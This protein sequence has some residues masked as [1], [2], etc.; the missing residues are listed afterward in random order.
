MDQVEVDAG[1]DPDVPAPAGGAIRGHGEVHRPEG[2]EAVELVEGGGRSVGDDSVGS[3]REALGVQVYRPGVDRPVDE[4]HSR[5]DPD[6]L[7]AGQEPLEPVAADPQF[8]QLDEGQKGVLS[9]SDSGQL[10]EERFHAFPP[11]HSPA[12]C[13][14]CA[15]KR[16]RK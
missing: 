12:K 1:V 3:G 7:P 15:A 11:E 4:E 13:R 16:R 14:A 8:A 6:Q 5:C 10:G 9:A 2:I